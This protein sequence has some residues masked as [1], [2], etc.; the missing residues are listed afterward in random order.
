MCPKWSYPNFNPT[1]N[2]LTKSPAPSSRVQGLGDLY[3]QEQHELIIVIV[4]IIIII[5]ISSK[6]N[7]HMFVV[8]VMSISMSFTTTIVMNRPVLLLLLLIL[9]PLLYFLSLFCRRGK[10][11]HHWQAVDLDAGAIATTAVATVLLCFC[12]RNCL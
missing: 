8:F 3:L 2:Q 7:I 10:L 11:H 1:C 12:F 4:I 9:P 5:K 6:N